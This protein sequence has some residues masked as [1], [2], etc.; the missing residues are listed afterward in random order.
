MQTKENQ[1]DADIVIK[2]SILLARTIQTYLSIKS[3]SGL[4]LT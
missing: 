3:R 2:A 1:E 4:F